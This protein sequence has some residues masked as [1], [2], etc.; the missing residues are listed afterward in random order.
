[1][2]AGMGGQGVR[3]GAEG[4][5]MGGR[6]HACTQAHARAYDLI[7][8]KAVHVNIRPHHAK[9]DPLLSFSVR[10]T[11]HACIELCLL[12]SSCHAHAH[13]CA[14]MRLRMYACSCTGTHTHTHK[15]TQASLLEAFTPV[16]AFSK[17]K[18]ITDG[19]LVSLQWCSQT[20]LGYLGQQAL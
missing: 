19:W 3:F 12:F 1:M 17:A 8:S 13:A 20:S 9:A 6:E 16:L 4:V 14:H 5:S 15:H 18:S 2:G 11:R 7:L 10:R